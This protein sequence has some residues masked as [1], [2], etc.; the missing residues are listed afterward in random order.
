MKSIRPY[1]QTAIEAVDKA[2]ARG[3]VKAL[4]CMATGTG[5]TFTA[6]KIVKNKGRVI[7]GSHEEGL[8]EQSATA[9]LIEMELMP[10]DNLM[11]AIKSS[12]GL[13]SLVRGFKK[14]PLFAGAQAQK[15][16]ETIGFIKADLFEINR[17]VV[18]ASMQTLHTR[19]DRIPTNH[20]DV[21]V[22]DECHLFASRTFQKSLDYFQ[23]KLRLGLSATPYREDGMLMGNIFD[24]IVYEYPIDKGIKDGFLCEIDAIRVKTNIELDAVHTVAGEFNKGEL[25]Q[26]VN[27]PARN[28]LIVNKYLEYAKGRQ[29]IAYTVDVEHCQDLAQCFIDKGIRVAVVVG[30]KEITPER[31]KIYDD[32]RA[33]LYDG[34]INV[35]VLVAG[36]DF[37]NVG[38]I[39]MGCPTKS[40]VKYVQSLGRGTRLKDELFVSKF[41]QNCI[42]LDFVDISSRHRLVNCW[43]MDKEKPLAERVYMTTQTRLKFESEREARKMAISQEKKDI[44]VDLFAL[45]TVVRHDTM[46]M[47]TDATEKQLSLLA[48]WGY[49]IVNVNYTMG[50]A[51]DIISARPASDKQIGYL[52]WKNYDVSNGVTFGEATLAFKEIQAREEKEKLAQQSAGAQIPFTDL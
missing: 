45:P 43:E 30:D 49:D 10:Y 40:K 4:L 51:S 52:K 9:A 5:K 14:N 37:P 12:G 2:M 42:V 11:W 50:Q 16:Y 7:W 18:F 29:F 8:I 24:E 25:Q 47:R 22:A 35:N 34:L 38:C 41:G 15:I 39:L 3:V 36:S 48:S 23:P 6:M 33:G 21:F 28:F 27:T 19:L 44:K 46:K 26:V 20:F 13:L 32:F 31:Q 17:P 1:Q